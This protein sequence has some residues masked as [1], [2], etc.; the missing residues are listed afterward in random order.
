MLDPASAW[1]CELTGYVQEYLDANGRRTV[2]EPP[3]PGRG[4][5]TGP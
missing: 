1:W 3:A 2:T 4:V 5:G